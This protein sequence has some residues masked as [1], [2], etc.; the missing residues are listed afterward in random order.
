VLATVKEHPHWK[1]PVKP[2][3]VIWFSAERRRR[4]PPAGARRSARSLRPV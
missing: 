1:A 4:W 3:R 2:G